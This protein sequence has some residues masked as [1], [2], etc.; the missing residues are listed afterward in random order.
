MNFS[1]V[2][3]ELSSCQNRDELKAFLCQNK[4]EFNVQEAKKSSA[5]DEDELE[6]MENEYIYVLKH[7]YKNDDDDE[8]E[9]PPDNENL[10]LLHQFGRGIVIRANF[11]KSP[12]E[13]HLMGLPIPFG[14]ENFVDDPSHDLKNCKVTTLI[15]GTGFNVCKDPV[16][17]LLFISTRAYGGYFPEGPTNHYRN[18][19]YTYG[20]MF[21]EALETHKMVGNMLDLPIGHSLHFVMNHEHDK[22]VY[23]VN[24]PSLHLVNV[25]NI[26]EMNVEYMDVFQ[27]QLDHETNFTIPVTLPLTSKQAIEDIIAHSDPK[28]TAGIKIFDPQN[29]VWSQRIYTKKYETLKNMFS[30]DTNILFTLIRLRYQEGQYHQ[31]MR[32]KEKDE[33]HK[34]VVS[35]FLENF[36]E[37]S[38]L[39]ESARHLIME[40]TGIIHDTYIAVYVNK[41]IDQKDAPF[42]FRDLIYRIH[43]T[44]Y[45]PQRTEYQT[46]IDACKTEEEKSKLKKPKIEAYHVQSFVNHLPPAQ[47]YDRLKRYS[48]R[49]KVMAEIFDVKEKESETVQ[50]LMDDDKPEEVQELSKNDIQELINDESIEIEITDE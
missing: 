38:A 39:Y 11:N 42:E 2:F 44:L 15:D 48:T 34:S 10:N 46:K 47:L 23:P 9:S 20:T 37:Y 29:N 16:S 21:R 24:E 17:N 45:L 4:F 36:P 19:Q 33:N 22:K 35:E 41:E 25:F 40:V 8:V 5:E 50:T 1:T 14:Q 3:S 18:H 27:Y 31:S 12:A 32:G 30:N 6:V 26:N 28:I 13:Y 7:P 49:E 43:H